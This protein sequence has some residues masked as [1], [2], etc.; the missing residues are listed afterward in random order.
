MATESPIPP[1]YAPPFIRKPD[2]RDDRDTVINPIWLNWFIEVARTI[3]PSSFDHENLSGLQGGS[4]GQHY[5]F[6]LSDYTALLAIISG[7]GTGASVQEAEVDLGSAWRQ[8]GS[9]TLTDANIVPASQI[10]ITLA[11]GPYTG[12]PGG[13]DELELVGPIVFG[14][15]P[16]TGSATVYWS[17]QFPQRGNV[18]IKYIRS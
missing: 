15:V 10:L 9:T 7:G 5:H 16:G 14:A 18:K 13:A 4:A 6:S 17:A 12:K 1:T 11:P 2:A 8:S 3:A